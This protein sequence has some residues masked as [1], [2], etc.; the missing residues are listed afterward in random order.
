MGEG[1]ATGLGSPRLELS[2]DTR[3]VET[4]DLAYSVADEL[5][6]ELNALRR[7]GAPNREAVPGTPL[8]ISVGGSRISSDSD[9]WANKRL[10]SVR[11]PELGGRLVKLLQTTTHTAPS[12]NIPYSVTAWRG[13]S[14]LTGDFKVMHS[15]EDKVAVSIGRHGYLDTGVKPILTELLN[16]KVSFIEAMTTPDRTV[17]T[18]D[19]SLLSRLPQIESRRHLLATSK[20]LDMATAIRMIQI[21]E[22]PLIALNTIGH[23][24][25]RLQ[26]QE[27][28]AA[29]AKA[30]AGN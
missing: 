27:I 14:D 9:D 24:F 5:I 16:P 26:A 7:S 10:V 17:W 25:T 2:P 12:S 22:D 20:I 23:L 21:G 3:A 13:T 15:P 19:S 29:K 8:H 1:G 28:A 4:F 18:P 30:S 6:T 11:V